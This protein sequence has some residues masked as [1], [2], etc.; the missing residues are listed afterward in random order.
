M[1][2]DTSTH[3]LGALRTEQVDAKFHMLDVMSVSELLSA[4]NESDA[5]VPRAVA[6]QLPA[7]EKA[8]DGVV[9]RMMQGGRLIYIG[10]GTSGR[11]GVLDAAECGPTFSVS[12]DQVLALIA[13]GDS[14]LRLPAEGAED[15]PQAGASDLKAQNLTSRDAVVGIAASG[16]TPYVLG[17]LAYAKEIGALTIGLTC[18]P[19]SE[20]SK[21]VDCPIEIDSGPELLA[22]STRLKSGTAQK[23]VLNMI[24]TITMVRLG[25]TF[26]NLMVDLQITNG[27]LKD[28]AIRIIEK[29]TGASRTLS[30]KALSD[31]GHEVKVAI[32]MLL[33]DIDADSARERLRASQNRVREALN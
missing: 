27:K 24:S 11:L 1:E 12:E 21:I 8:I 14:A 22:G 2:F 9:D 29:A 17:A 19:N 28:R 15:K 31:S 4:M 10:A 6:L 32:L 30:E 33:L 20:I 23:L 3:A 25:K 18:N 16:R 13:G 26:G 7:I 5:E